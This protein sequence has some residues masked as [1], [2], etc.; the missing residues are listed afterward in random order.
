MFRVLS[1]ALCFVLGIAFGA[2]AD[3]VQFSNGDRL[4]GKVVSLE[5]GKLV[6]DSK[7][8]GKVEV[9]WT[10]VA[11][12]ATDEPVTLIL[13]DDSVIVDKVA[14]AEAGTVRTVGTA[15]ISPQTVAL[16]NATKVNP[17]PVAWHGKA[18]AGATLDRGNTHRTAGVANIDAVRRAEYDRITF[19]A[20]YQAERTRDDDTGDD[21][22]TKSQE[23][24]NLQY[25]L[26]FRPK[27]YMLATSRAEKDRVAG[28]DL[29][30]TTGV[31]L[32][33]QFAETNELNASLELGPT[34]VSEHYEDGEND[35]DYVAARVAWKLD[36]LM[37]TGVTFFHYGRA[38]PSLEDWQ[39][40]FVA[41]DT[42]FRYKLFDDFYGES[43]VHW[44]WDSTPA[45]D[46]ERVDMTVI[47]GLGYGF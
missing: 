35:N 14:A 11:T 13:N 36:W 1:L 29:R 32:G 6:L 12:F 44:E 47:L 24:V 45:E 34:W 42:G 43:K 19:G 18:F 25:D 22:T 23:F 28:L 15:L 5:D 2:G 31:G 8:A 27:W 40:Q 39:D 10:D 17:E 4:S 37:L 21:V 20:G 9:K 30:L 33:Y 46:K 38:L 26:F 7:L 3:E 41:T 16:A